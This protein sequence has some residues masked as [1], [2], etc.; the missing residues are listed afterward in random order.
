MRMLSWFVV[1][2]I[3]AVAAR[4]QAVGK[5]FWAERLQALARDDARAGTLAPVGERLWATRLLPLPGLRGEAH[6]L[7]HTQDLRDPLVVSFETLDGAPVQLALSGQRWTPTHS[8]VE[9]RV[10]GGGQ[11]RERR[12]IT[13][14]DTFVS[15]FTCQGLPALRMRWRAP[16]AQQPFGEQRQRP[17]ALG[18]G[19]V[20]LATSPLVRIGEPV[21]PVWIE[22][23]ACLRQRGSLGGDKKA[24]ASGGE[25]L[26]AEFGGERGDH[27][28][29]RF[30]HPQEGPATVFV[31]YTRQTAGPARVRVAIEGRPE[32]ANEVDLASTG[33]W[34]EQPEHLALMRVPLGALPLGVLELR[35]EVLADGGNVNVDGMFVVPSAAEEFTPPPKQAWRWLDP[36][37]GGL[38]VD[39][40]HLD[41]DG[42]RFVL[43]D[44]AMGRPC[45]PS[46]TV[47]LDATDEWVHVLALPTGD[48]ASLQLDDG[49]VRKLGPRERNLAAHAVSLFA[50]GRVQHL[51]LTQCVLLGVTLERPSTGG[52]DLRRGDVTFH[53]VRTP[54]VAGVHGVDAARQLPASDLPASDN[55]PVRAFATIEFSGEGEPGAATEAA[56][57]GDDPFAAHVAASV[58]WYARNAPRLTCADRGLQDLWTYRAFLLRHNLATP[59]AG[60]LSGGPVFYEGRHGSWYPRVITFST[61]H[62]VAESRWLA[63]PTLWQANV[64]AHLRNVQPGEDLPNL[65]VDW[66]GFRYTNW[67]AE[68][69]VEACK[70][71]GDRATL[72]ELLPPLAANVQFLAKQ[73]DPDG[74][75]LLAPGDHYTTGMEF[76]PS[77][78][79]HA[80]YDNSKP[81]TDLERPDFNAYTYGNAMALAAGARWLGDDAT[82][83]AMTAIATRIQRATLTKLWHAE[84]SFFYS[85]READDD[86]AR[87]AEVIGFYPFRFGLA[88]LEPTYTRA[89]ARLFDPAQ[90]QARFS[91]TSCGRQVPVFSASVQQWPGPGGVIQPCM[92][93][94][95]VWPHATSLVADAL[96][97]VARTDP[98]AARTLHLEARLGELLRAYAAF[99][100]ENGDPKRPLLRE[101]GD[102]DTGR[103]WGCADYLHS[104]FQDLVIC[105]WAGLIPRFDDT[106]EIRPLALG[107]GDLHLERIPYHGHFL[108]IR[109]QGETLT[110]HVD[111]KPLE[112]ARARDGI[113]HALR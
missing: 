31:R 57:A 38:V 58:A 106:L 111:G 59:N 90:F 54:V 25:V 26:G 77:F 23:E 73:F 8:E 84:D 32:T 16:L 40:P 78:W 69:V 44:G 105:H 104:T 34:G 17:V 39:G 99:H 21:D 87:C 24:A 91:V 95:P 80:G 88:P 37:R 4:A 6:Y 35:L 82:A 9:Y 74:D 79:F 85:V 51:Y 92:W 55:G 11:V 20:S 109:L 48:E 33:G 103:N 13:A 41:L 98:T 50:R 81:Q 56:M 36:M 5:A 83:A 1:W 7:H 108:D 94:G 49:T 43:P 89:L 3:S 107:L 27:A 65:L 47:D 52:A 102:A 19:T 61:P 10:G 18:P 72:A 14:A 75:G 96:A 12:W 68:T 42:V 101:Y 64:R 93:N 100:R 46:S 97:R 29:W 30:V 60:F 113:Q 67:I 66:R 71:R 62:I 76:Q 112:S 22:G 63:D 28:V 45:T 86:P 2:S 70:A 110:V 53:G 15:E